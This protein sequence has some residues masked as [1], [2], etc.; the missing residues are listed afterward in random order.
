MSSESNGR[1]IGIS[2]CY[3]F[4]T[5]GW[6]QKEYAQAFRARGIAPLWTMPEGFFSTWPVMRRGRPN[7]E[8]FEHGAGYARERLET[9]HRMAGLVVINNAHLASQRRH[10]FDKLSTSD[11]ELWTEAK[12]SILMARA[13][14]KPV[15]LTHE[16]PPAVPHPDRDPLHDGAALEAMGVQTI[17]S[18]GIDMSDQVD[19]I[20]DF[21]FN[22][23]IAQP[24]S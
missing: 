16:M 18:D 5:T 12:E 23:V 17:V 9:I 1:F 24:R 20:V 2:T 11:L 10:S 13:A 19:R 15:V 21:I 6:G 3:R 8:D 14:Q 7:H 4:N 22:D